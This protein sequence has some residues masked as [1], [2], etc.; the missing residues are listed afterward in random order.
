M[1]CRQDCPIAEVVCRPD[2][3]TDGCT[4]YTSAKHVLREEF[5]YK[6]FRSG[7]LEVVIPA[8]HKKDVVGK[9]GNRC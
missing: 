3:V 8:L 9:N 5:N 1:G 4:A 7:Q 2:V 6:T